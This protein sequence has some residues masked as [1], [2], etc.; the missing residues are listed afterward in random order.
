MVCQSRSHAA[1]ESWEM[2]SSLLCS[3]KLG[4]I[5]VPA[6]ARGQ[7]IERRFQSRT[8]YFRC[9]QEYAVSANRSFNGHRSSSCFAV[10][11][12]HLFLQLSMLSSRDSP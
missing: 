10:T 6:S 11:M 1:F 8:C 2:S 7:L 9:D 12:K 3:S 4:T 5:T